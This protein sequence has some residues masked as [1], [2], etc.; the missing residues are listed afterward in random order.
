MRMA[1]QKAPDEFF[2]DI[3]NAGLCVDLHLVGAFAAFHAAE[4]LAGTA[5]NNEDVVAAGSDTRAVLTAGH[6]RAE[7]RRAVV[8]GPINVD[9]RVV[10]RRRTLFQTGAPAPRIRR[11]NRVAAPS[12]IAA[13]RRFTHLSAA[14]AAGWSKPGEPRAGR[15]RSDRG[16]AGRRGDGLR[17]AG[18]VAVE[19][20]IDFLPHRGACG[21]F[22]FPV[23]RFLVRCVRLREVYFGGVIAEHP[24]AVGDR[25]RAQTR[26][27]RDRPAAL[28]CK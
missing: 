14:G 17:Q 9:H 23:S 19:L 1:A 18:L 12:R 21:L 2:A 28:P 10:G 25:E 20:L 26:S 16:L 3:V 4:N 13:P 24:V 27:R 7:Q 6:R 5:R 8:V 11:S 15:G 22:H